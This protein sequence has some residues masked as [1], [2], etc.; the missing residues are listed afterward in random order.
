MVGRRIVLTAHPA[1]FFLGEEREMQDQARGP[2]PRRGSPRTAAPAGK[3]RRRAGQAAAESSR[4]RP[5]VPA[6]P[7]PTGR[8]KPP[9][10]RDP[11][12]RPRRPRQYG[13]HLPE[14]GSRRPLSDWDGPA[15]R[16]R[17]AGYGAE[18]GVGRDL[19]VNR[20][21]IVG[22]VGQN[23][24]AGAGP[25]QPAA[26][27]GHGAAEGL[28]QRP[29]RPPAEDRAGLGPIQ[30]KGF[31]FMRRPRCVGVRSPGGAPTPQGGQAIGE[32]SRR[33]G[34]RRLRAEVPRLGRR[35]L[36]AP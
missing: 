36:A 15:A 3:R 35:G 31:G 30:T 6:P 23:E 7:L 24:G 4:N 11:T 21:P 19:G 1:G 12:S 27:P 26:L 2:E 9:G 22:D 18:P 28:F 33:P 10:W 16:S 14:D 8:A 17:G 13:R 32:P 20:R 34:V 25:G 5:H 29:D